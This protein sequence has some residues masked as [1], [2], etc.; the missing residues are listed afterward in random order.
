M[1]LLLIGFAIIGILIGLG[2]VVHAIV[3]LYRSGWP[4]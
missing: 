4:M 2:V 3:R 1:K